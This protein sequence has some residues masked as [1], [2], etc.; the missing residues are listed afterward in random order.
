MITPKELKFSQTHEW[1]KFLDDG[2]ALTG[3]SYYAQNAL[4][5]IV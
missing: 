4:G 1:I 2:T 3:L 5:D